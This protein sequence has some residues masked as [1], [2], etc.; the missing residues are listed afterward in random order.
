MGPNA[1]RRMPQKNKQEKY[2]EARIKQLMDDMNKASDEYDKQWY[3]RLIQE[4]T[5]VQDMG[6]TK[7]KTNCYMEKTHVGAIGGKEIWT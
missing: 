5:W 2:I 6:G 3:N 7:A 4:L 1:F